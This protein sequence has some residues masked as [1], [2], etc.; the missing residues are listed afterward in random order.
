MEGF[1]IKAESKDYFQS[2]IQGKVVVEKEVHVHVCWNTCHDQVSIA[3]LAMDSHS[4]VFRF[5][6]VKSLSH[7]CLLEGLGLS[8][9]QLGF[10]MTSI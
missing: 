9:L 1:K 8:A 2:Q 3:E 5:G 10:P 4:D 7:R 6:G